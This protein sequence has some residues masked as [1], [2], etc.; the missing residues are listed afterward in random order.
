MPVK[1]SA[2]ATPYRPWRRRNSRFRDGVDLYPAGGE[3]RNRAVAGGRFP[4][5]E[6]ARSRGYRRTVCGRW[7][8]GDGVLGRANSDFRP[9]HLRTPARVR[10]RLP[11]I[12]LEPL[13]S[14]LRKRGFEVAAE[15]V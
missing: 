12:S 8:D 1:R 14:V 5:A 7:R 10:N 4:C 6:R 15:H 9:R 13:Y 3:L 2:L 11:I